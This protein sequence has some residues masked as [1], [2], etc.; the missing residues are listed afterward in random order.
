VL[1]LKITG[2]PTQVTRV[3]VGRVELISNEQRAALARLSAGPCPDLAAVKKAA[4]EALRKSTMSVVE[5][6]AFY[7]GEKP[8]SALGIT[9]PPLIE[10]YLSM[11]RFRDALIVHEQ[12]LHPSP[13][14]AQFIKDN[15]LV[16]GEK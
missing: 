3:M 10:D 13:A 16:S 14:L 9:I 5:K 2:A 11:G 7:R 4:F 8:L 6:E 12:Q 1:P 15:G